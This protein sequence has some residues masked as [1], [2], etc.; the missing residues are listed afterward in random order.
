MSPRRHLRHQTSASALAAATGGGVTAPLRF[1]DGDLD[2]AA[3]QQA[4][5]RLNKAV[6]DLRTLTIQ[7][8]LQRAVAA[9]GAEDHKS[10]AE[11]ALKVLNRD[12]RNGYGWYI[13]A[14]ARERAGDFKSSI[15]CYESA[16]A[17]LPNH[18]DIANDLGR[19]ALRLDNPLQA[20]K[21]FAIY[22]EANPDCAHGANN[23]ANALRELNDY[24]GAIEML[25][26][27]ILAHPEASVL[28]N[29]L[30][31]VMSEQGF[32]DK[33]VTFYEEALRLEPSFAKARH[34]LANAKLDLNDIDGALADC[35]AAMLTAIGP[36][37]M[38]MIRLARSA[39]LLCQGRVADGWEA[40]EARLD[41]YF[42]SATH[43]MIDRPRWKPEDDLTGKSLLLMGEQGLGDEVLFANMV[44]DILD[45][46]GPDG[47]LSIA[48][49]RRLI[50]LF[51]RSFPTANIGAHS[52]YK[53][54]GVT[55][56]GAPF[57]NDEPIDLWTPMASPVRRFRRSV[58]AYPQRPSFMIADPERVTYWRDLVSTLPGP[59]I[60]LLWKSLKLGGARLKQFSPF[61]QWRPV[62]ETQGVSFINLQYGDCDAEL[63]EAHSMLGVEIWQPPGI[64]LKND[65]DEVAALSCAMDLILGPSNATTNIAAACGASV[66]V[67]SSPAAWPL[68][69][70]DHHP[71]YPQARMFIADGYHNWGELMPRVA[72]AL[73]QEAPKLGARP[74]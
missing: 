13:L 37:D 27:A 2:R 73:G 72:H 25:R 51:Q 30:G 22:C 39:M 44:P 26:P 32:S 40:Y 6:A 48:V 67:V 7:P 33:A 70:T 61:E 4:L 69:G 35:D 12:E 21:F 60:G 15:S 63:A 68:L 42:A 17:L 3:S 58:D 50:P 56:R 23:M 24:D 34:N 55:I 20:A 54:D 46:L 36:S 38:A 43:F 5:A 66:W 8:L 59:K 52:T 28:W 19:L 9:I 64:D 62:L 57:M 16:L 65:L 1:S 11:L 45:A 18:S 71:W 14:I 29:T 74:A 10:A 41:P 31:S 53:V 49:E 47:R